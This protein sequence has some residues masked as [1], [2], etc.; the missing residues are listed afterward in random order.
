MGS[1]RFASF[2]RPPLPEDRRFDV[3]F[4]ADGTVWLAGIPARDD[5]RRLRET[6]RALGHD[7]VFSEAKSGE[8]LS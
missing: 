8:A 4:D 2:E 5:I 1:A 6:M 7:V 3:M